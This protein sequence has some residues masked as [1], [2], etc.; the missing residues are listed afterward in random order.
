MTI[1]RAVMYEDFVNKIISYCEL[2]C[3]LKDLVV[4]YMHCCSEK[5]IVA[6]FRIKYCTYLFRR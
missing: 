1:D 2:N 4:T 6:P 5:Q 3:E